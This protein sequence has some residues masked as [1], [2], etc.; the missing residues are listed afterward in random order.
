[1]ARGDGGVQQQ[2]PVYT[3]GPGSMGA[4]G[5]VVES[6]PAPPPPSVPPALT[7]AIQVR[8]PPQRPLLQR[9][10]QQPPPAGSSF[11]S[12]WG[13]GS[14]SKVDVS[15]S[16]SLLRNA[17]GPGC[18]ITAGWVI[19]GSGNHIAAAAE[20]AIGRARGTAGGPGRVP[21][22][23]LVYLCRRCMNFC[24]YALCSVFRS[25]VG[26]FG[27]RVETGASRGPNFRMGGPNFCTNR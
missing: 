1:M 23:V 20:L 5:A 8:L 9:Q 17:A 19:S 7:H 18:E 2:Q 26:A 15:C 4:T 6:L 14:E 16:V 12:A 13:E 25:S 27:W 10:Q 21:T 11:E 24:H 3:P 22:A